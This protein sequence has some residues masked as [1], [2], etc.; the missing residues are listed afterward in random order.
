MRIE[1]GGEA[2]L[3]LAHAPRRFRPELSFLIMNDFVERNSVVRRAWGDPDVILLIFAGAAAEFALNRAVDWLFFT[4]RLP[5]DPLGRLFSTV[6]YAQGI[7]FADEAEARATLERINDA[8]ARVERARGGR[9]P[10]WAYRDVLYLLVAYTER[11]YELLERRLTAAEQEELFAVFRRVGEALKVSELPETYD[12]WLTDRARHLDRDLA[13]SDYTGRLYN[14]YRRHLGRW[15]YELLL[16]VQALLVPERA[17]ELL[18]L[19]GPIKQLPLAGA[20][21][22]YRLCD[23]GRLRPLVRRALVPRDHW[24]D[25]RRLGRDEAVFSLAPHRPVHTR[26][27]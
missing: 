17:R 2:G 15:R 22:A 27:R 11:A 1:A 23:R 26:R 19:P 5:G 8:H 14:A 21:C 18:Q 7:V 9:I 3:L 10:E 25:V 16:G 13:Y 6:R 24:E 20:V 12:G 4:G